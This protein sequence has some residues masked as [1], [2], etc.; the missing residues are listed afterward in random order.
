MSK[1]TRKKK[2]SK[3]LKQIDAEKKRSQQDN[4]RELETQTP[5]RKREL[6]DVGIIFGVAFVLR[7]VFFF[8]SKQNNP[9]FYYPIMD[10]L[11]HHEWAEEIISG[12]FW[13][14]EAFFRAPLYPYFL[15][16]LYKLSGS[17]IG[18]AVF[19]QHMIG[20][21]TAVIIYFLAREYFTRKI[22]LLAGAL[23][24]LYWPFV[25]FEGELLIVTLILFLDVA[26]LWCLAFG[27]R[28]RKSRLFIAAGIILGLSAVARPSILIFILVLP[29]ALRYGASSKE[30]TS[31]KSLWR[32][33]TVLVLAGTILIVLPVI[34]RNYIVGRDIVPIASQ[35][36]VNFYIGNNPQSDGRTAI[37]PGTR[38]DWWGGYYDTIARA[39]AVEG[40]KLKP[41]EVSSYYFKEGFRFIGTSP[42]AAAKLLFHKFYLFW[43]GGERSN[44]KYIYFFWDLTGM[45]KV[46]LPG[47]W[48]ITPLALL[49]GILQWR[50]RKLL[51]PLYLFVMSYMVGVVAFFVNARFRLPVVSVLIGFAA[52]AVFHLVTAYRQ[53]SFE[54]L[55][56]ILILVACAFAIN[57]DFFN[58]RENKPHED[59]ISRYSLGNAF[60][61]MGEKD[62]AI[63]EY[64]KA[65]ITYR[66]Y[67]RSSFGLV[68]RNVNY[69]LGVLYWENGLCSR[70]I[71]ALEKVGGFDEYTILAWEHLA[72]CYL[73]KG[74]MN[75]AIETYS[76]ITSAQPENRLARIGLARAH[77]LAGDIDRSEEII[78]ALLEQTGGADGEAH[79]ELAAILERKGDLSAAIES[80]QAA[81]RV[82]SLQMDAFLGL[83]R[84]YRRLG[85]EEE[86]LDYIS[87]AQALQRRA[88]ELEIGERAIK[89]LR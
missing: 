35:G 4:Y 56:V 78:R 57:Y 60:L 62:L 71:E 5:F 86:A 58:F 38:P 46:P 81:A 17:S 47:F 64:E 76:K 7:L 89:G 75:D 22:A 77:R 23:A 85:R 14:D 68:A 29:F 36:G 31:S 87:K 83:A 13:G 3:P 26:F 1:K 10:S 11:Y 79:Y 59:S 70:A 67:P 51:A 15:A 34:I 43:A 82:P 55:K 73:K 53:K 28:R 48:L 44:N 16:L 39:E 52:Y 69:N 80:Y 66:R 72:D 84:V 18:F 20:S 8:L 24:A 33:Q 32:Q 45:R 6:I 54:A 2:P 61:K 25:Y 19:C 88:Q 30:E 21:L 40:R 50:R 27:L 37:V 49:G 74:R 63:A 12:N 9:L 42:G 65:L 41:S